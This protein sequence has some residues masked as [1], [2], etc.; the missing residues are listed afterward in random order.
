MWLANLRMLWKSKLYEILYFSYTLSGMGA[1]GMTGPENLKLQFWS[2]HWSVSSKSGPFLAKYALTYKEF[3]LAI[4]MLAVHTKQWV[5]Y[6]HTQSN[7]HIL[8]F[9][10]ENI[11][12]W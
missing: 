4:Q 11:S 5:L 2:V 10:P 3:F 6:R 1:T 7:K 8:T 9:T 12:M